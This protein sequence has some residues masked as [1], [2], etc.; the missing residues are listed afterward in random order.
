MKRKGFTLIELL[1]VIAII[2]VLAGLLLQPDSPTGIGL[3]T[4]ARLGGRGAGRYPGPAG[5]VRREPPDA[6]RAVGARAAGLPRG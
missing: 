6:R 1:V 5:R 4:G 2:G 3:A